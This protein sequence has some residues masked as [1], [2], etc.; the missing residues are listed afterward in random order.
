[1]VLISIFQC[2]HIPS[3]V[4]EDRLNLKWHVQR[5]GGWH[6]HRLNFNNSKSIFFRRL[7]SNESACQ[8]HNQ[9]IATLAEEPESSVHAYPYRLGLHRPH[10]EVSS[11]L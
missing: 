6:A 2:N 3:L 10:Q 4:G 7:S 11:K 8:Q 5:E 9:P 1:M